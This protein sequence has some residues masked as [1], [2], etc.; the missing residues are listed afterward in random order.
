MTDRRQFLATL[1]GALAHN[2]FLRAA[3]AGSSDHGTLLWR[4][5][6]TLLD[7]A[8]SERRARF[9]KLQESDLPELRA[10]VR[11]TLMTALGAFP[12]RTSLNARQ[13]GTLTRPDYVIEKIIFES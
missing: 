7:T 1:T 4:H 6:M 9:A 8:D 13:V 2:G 10:R 12:P 11:H 5:F 3:D